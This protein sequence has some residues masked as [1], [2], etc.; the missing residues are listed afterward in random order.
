MGK[1]ED[2]TNHENDDFAEES[3]GEIASEDID[4]AISDAE[5]DIGGGDGEDK[6]PVEDGG[7]DPSKATDEAEEDPL[8]SLLADL[9]RRGM[10]QG[11]TTTIISGLWPSWK[12]SR[13]A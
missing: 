2:K 10:R 12:T 13:N 1:K 6:I 3:T 9:E 8:E 11:R 7:V 5:T 4:K